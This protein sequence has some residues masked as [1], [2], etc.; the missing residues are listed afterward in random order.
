[1]APAAYSVEETEEEGEKAADSEERAA[2]EARAA[3]EAD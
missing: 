2:T 3:M 1:V